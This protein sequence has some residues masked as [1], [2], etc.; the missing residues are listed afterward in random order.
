MKNYFIFTSKYNN[1]PDESLKSILLLIGL[2][3]FLGAGAHEP[4]EYSISKK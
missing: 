2:A 1:F 4:I 3:A